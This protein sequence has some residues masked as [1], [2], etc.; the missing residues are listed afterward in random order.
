MTFRS[1]FEYDTRPSVRMEMIVAE[2]DTEAFA[3]VVERMM[4]RLFDSR[5]END[6][7]RYL[8]VQ[9]GYDDGLDDLARS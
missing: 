2:G 5:K 1:S 7:R 9:A 6:R 3:P 8:R 4:K